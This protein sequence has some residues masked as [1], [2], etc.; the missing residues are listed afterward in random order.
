M[1]KAGRFACIFL[2]YLLTIG[3]LVCLVL[4]G[5]GSTKTSR[6]LNN[7][8][9]ARVD[10]H[11]IEPGP[12][13]LPDSTFENIAT[14]LGQADGA[15]KLEDF[16]TIGL[17][18]HCWGKYDDGDYIVQE[19]SERETK[20]WFDPIEV[21]GLNDE[22]DDLLPEKLTKGMDAYKN[23]ASWLFV[24]YVVAVVATAVQLLV[25]IT[26]IF[27]RWGSFA[28]TIFASVS[29]FFTLAASATATALYVI[30]MGAISG[31]L[32]PF[33]IKATLGKDMFVI[34]WFAVAFSLASGLFWLFSVCCCSGRSPYSH[35]KRGRG[36]VAEKTP[37]TYERVESPYGGPSY[38]GGQAVPLNDMSAN[39]ETAYEPYRHETTRV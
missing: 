19:C 22:V 39:R 35:D 23:A 7:I 33:N 27:S 10:L 26:A 8:Y 2:P 31:G 38:G 16:Y 6:P 9:F 13:D 17:W 20:Y 28:T 25:G 12:I 37:Y 15:G 11:D 29:A 3:A 4:V 24:A 5:L 30:L 14:A 21:W 18:N 32:K 1:G 36:T 34:T